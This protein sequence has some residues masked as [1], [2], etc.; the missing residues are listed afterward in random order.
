MGKQILEVLLRERE[1]GVPGSCGRRALGLVNLSALRPNPCHRPRD[2]KFETN[3]LNEA[4]RRKS[5]GSLHGHRARPC[6]QAPAHPH[7]CPFAVHMTR[8]PYPAPFTLPIRMRT[9]PVVLCPSMYSRRCNF[10]TSK[11]RSTA[12]SSRPS[13]IHWK[14]P[15]CAR[16]FLRGPKVVRKLGPAHF[17]R[18]LVVEDQWIEGRDGA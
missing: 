2:A 13:R 7:V 10:E 11:V 9:F 6:L 3:Y 8:R 17:E 16:A 1:H 18:T 4:Q 15:H 14:A 5:A 12:T